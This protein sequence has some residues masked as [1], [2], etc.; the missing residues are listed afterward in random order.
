MNTRLV[1]TVSAQKSF[2]EQVT[3]H[4]AQH[5]ANTQGVNHAMLHHINAFHGEV[6]SMADITEEFCISFSGFL[7][8]RV[9]P[10]SVRTY[11]QKM[12]AILER[13]VAA[14]LIPANPMPPIKSL[15]PSAKGASRVHLTHDDLARLS[16]TYCWNG[17]T[18]RESARW[19]Y[20]HKDHRDLR[21]HD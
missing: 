12:H 8:E 13:A 19:T 15:I 2:S 21:P 11:L 5:R 17:D 6:P 4:E 3:L 9:A 7:M 20:N 1:K 10:S 16:K 18:C 14:H